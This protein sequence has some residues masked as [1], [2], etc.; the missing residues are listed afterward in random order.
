M[1]ALRNRLSDLSRDEL[2]QRILE[3]EVALTEFQESSR[4][5]EKALEDELHDLES[6]NTNMQKQ[7]NELKKQL[8]NSRR[9]NKELSN[10]ID[11]L[12]EHIHKNDKEIAQLRQTLVNVEITNDTMENQDRIMTSKYEVQ[13]SLN[14]QLLEKL[15][16]LE[17][18]LDRTK[19]ANM[20]QG[21]HVANYKI[22]IKDLQTKIDTIEQRLKQEQEQKQKRKQEMN[23]CVDRGGAS[24]ISPLDE[25]DTLFLSIREMLKS[26]PPPDKIRDTSSS[27]SS[28]NNNN[29]NCNS[30]YQMGRLKKSD[31][32]QKLKNLTRDIEVFLGKQQQRQHHQHQHE[33][34]DGLLSRLSMLK[35]PS[36]TQ[37]STM[38]DSTATRRDR[39]SKRISYS[40]RFSDLPSIG[41]SPISQRLMK[42]ST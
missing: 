8:E 4:D 20:E 10:E 2:I 15:A 14:N 30:S 34:G 31:S 6:N 28:N 38:E 18:E 16:I 9:H 37:L 22:Q 26:T 27:T 7:I 40:K 39:S 19:K 25:R 11:S 21:L 13:Q 3:S 12:Q 36:T 42:E 35:S 17:D 29:N 32:L 5:L 24:S 1:D 41:G 23:K 33:Q